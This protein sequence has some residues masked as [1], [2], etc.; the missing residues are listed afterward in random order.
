MAATA[1]FFYNGTLPGPEGSIATQMSGTDIAVLRKNAMDLY[2]F[3]INP[4]RQLLELNMEPSLPTTC[5]IGL[6]MSSKVRVLHCP[7]VG[8][9]GIGANSSIDGR[10]LFLQGDGNNDIGAPS[11]LTLP[12][13]VLDTNTTICMTREQFDST[14]A[15]QG[16]TYSWPL[17]TRIRAH[18]E[19][20]TVDIMQIAPVPAFLVLD[21]LVGDIDAV[22]L[23]ERIDALADATQA[24]Y[25]HLK[26][27]LLA[28]LT[29]HNQGDKC[30]RM[31]T[32][33]LVRPTPP[34]ARRWAREKFAK[35]FPALQPPPVT[36][37]A[38]A[39]GNGGH[40]IAALLAQVMAMQQ[41]QQPRPVAEEKKETDNDDTNPMGMS[42]DELN[43]TFQMCGLPAGSNVA[44]L[45]EWIRLCAAKG[46][47]DSYKK[48]IIRKHIM[49][50]FCYEDAQVPLTN[51]ILKMASKKNW[52]GNEAN[53]DCPS[54][55]NAGDG[56][57]PFIVLDLDEDEVATMNA[58]EDAL[59]TASSVTP[60]ELQASK[61][62]AAVP[63]SAEAFLLMQMRYTNLLFA[64]FGA[65]CPLYKCVVS[66]VDAIKA[67]SRSARG[68]MSQVTRASILWVI[69]KQSRRFALGEMN[70][71]QEFR[72]MHDNLAYKMLGFTHAETPVALYS[73]KGD[74]KRKRDQE[75]DPPKGG[76]PPPVKAPLRLGAPGNNPNSWH[77]K[78]KA[79]LEPAMKA[80]KNP[81]FL[82]IMTFVD[83]D[84][85]QL[86]GEFK[87]KCLPN[88]FFG[89][90]TRGVDCPRLHTHPDETQIAKILEVTKKFRDN[91]TGL[92]QG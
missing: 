13:T 29:S 19:S 53:V 17:T 58:E 82:K 23:M 7:G 32:E 34:Q 91:P 84:A 24:M 6:P 28:C 76:K 63:D 50:N 55:V 25:T 43:T 79:A 67:F 49:T 92:L 72:G 37:Q 10:L 35:T 22:E 48:I 68:K 38:P 4:D 3:F 36:Q 18:A 87:K 5:I 27:F 83:Q 39:Q 85:T 75:E 26:S 14:L 33:T 77:P 80:A 89:S 61:R 62:K 54:L 71:I 90:C 11:P 78:V 47:S 57:S 8:A 74:K 56:L 69:L 21:G 30:P 73:T 42:Q 59:A 60:T 64:L 15:T 45:P 16:A 51:T 9:S 40:D 1:P 2:E 86:Y 41:M 46:T 44:L 20:N 66:I 88:C 12:P 81:G 31:D 52:L 65:Q 70:I